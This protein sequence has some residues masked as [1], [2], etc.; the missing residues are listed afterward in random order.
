MTVPLFLEP[1]CLG[2]RQSVSPSPAARELPVGRNQPGTSLYLQDDG[3]RFLHLRLPAPNPAVL[4]LFRAD[5]L[6]ATGRPT[7]ISRV[8]RL[9][10]SSGTSLAGCESPPSHLLAVWTTIVPLCLGF[11]LEKRD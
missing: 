2:A 9:T 10:Q 6:L 5:Q 7:D 11:P 4:L 8:P 3:G 1:S